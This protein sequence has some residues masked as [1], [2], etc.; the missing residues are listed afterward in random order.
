M[1]TQQA[2]QQAILDSSERKKF[3]HFCIDVSL[4]QGPFELLKMLSWRN[5]QLIHPDPSPPLV[6]LAWQ[7]SS[8]AKMGGLP[9]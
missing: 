6:A 9:L 4:H 1:M 8:Y 5:N 7:E 3:A 2:S